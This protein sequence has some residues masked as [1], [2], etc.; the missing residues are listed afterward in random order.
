MRFFLELKVVSWD[1]LT[2]AGKRHET[3][4]KNMSFRNF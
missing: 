3:A 4:L 2:R 1:D